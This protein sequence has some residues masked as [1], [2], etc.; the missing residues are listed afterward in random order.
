MKLCLGNS[1]SRFLN[2]LFSTYKRRLSWL[3]QTLSNNIIIFGTAAAGFFQ[4]FPLILLYCHYF[5]ILE[6]PSRIVGYQLKLFDVYLSTCNEDDT[7]IIHFIGSLVEFVLLNYWA[8]VMSLAPNISKKCSSR[9]T[10][11]TAGK[12][13][14]YIIQWA[15]AAAPSENF[16]WRILSNTMMIVLVPLIIWHRSNIFKTKQERYG[17][18]NLQ[19]N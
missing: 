17:R 12:Q 18:E 6:V 10:S 7:M 5:G 3:I 11:S 19:R 1:V 8:T 13:I 9:W 15:N 2:K 14:L 4:K 16:Y